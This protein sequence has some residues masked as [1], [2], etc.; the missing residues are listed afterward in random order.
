[1]N[2]WKIEKFSKTDRQTYGRRDTRRERERE[3]E[4]ERAG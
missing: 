1:M 2:K 4:R 3:R